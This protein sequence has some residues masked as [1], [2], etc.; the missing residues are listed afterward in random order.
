MMQSHQHS[1]NSSPFPALPSTLSQYAY[2]KVIKSLYSI[3][4]STYLKTRLWV[5][6]SNKLQIPADLTTQAA[7]SRYLTKGFVGYTGNANKK[8][9]KPTGNPSRKDTVTQRFPVQSMQDVSRP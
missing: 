9:P 8:F 7:V 1:E 2:M 5:E 3:Q 6:V 4:N